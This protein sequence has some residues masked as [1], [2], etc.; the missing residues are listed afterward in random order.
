MDNLNIENNNSNDNIKI[1]TS[2]TVPT[3]NVDII[4]SVSEGNEIVNNKKKLIIIICLIF[5][6]ILSFIGATYLITNQLKKEQEINQVSEESNITESKEENNEI[7]ESPDY[8]EEI[9]NSIEDNISAEEDESN[10]KSTFEETIDKSTNDS[11]STSSSNTSS[12][13]NSNSSS[14]SGNTPTTPSPIEV[15]TSKINLNNYSSDIIITKGGEY[16]LSG[17]L[18]YTVYINADSQVTL[19]LNGVTIKSNTDS[20]IANINTE[21][22]NINIV[23]NTSNIVSDGVVDSKYDGA[24]FSYGNLTINGNGNLSVYGNQIDGEGIATKYVPITING[25]NINI[26]AVDDGINTGKTGGT[27]TIN[28]GTLFIKAGGDGIDSNKNIVI[29]GGTIYSIGA[30]RGAD[31]GL[32]ADEGI[33]I[34]G[35]TVIAT[36]AVLLE[37]PDKTS[38]QNVLAFAFRTMKKS[39]TLYT[40]LD[41]NDNVIV[42]FESMDSFSTLIISSKELINGTYHLYCGGDNNGTLNNGIYT[43]GTYNKGTILDVD[44]TTEFVVEDKINSYLSSNAMLAKS[45]NIIKT[46][47]IEPN[48]ISSKEETKTYDLLTI[49]IASML[50]IIII[51]FTYKKKTHSN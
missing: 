27:I 45:S 46:S 10:Q 26:Y 15:T 37:K 29:N 8:E 17:S 14:N 6:I 4:K 19:N 42:S 51:K 20:A 50:F 38:K 30:S 3:N 25:G 23:E 18:N 41:S 43:G 2:T 9:S 5:L 49:S 35:G 32:D 12:N 7:T 39:N 16:T 24:I 31:S 33:E 40:L 13:N 34:N 47:T 48:I 1:N 28:D 36:G 11:N 22:L 44:G 21:N